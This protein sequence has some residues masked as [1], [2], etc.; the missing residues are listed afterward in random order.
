MEL[1]R[2]V[3][4]LAT[5]FLPDRQRH[6]HFPHLHAVPHHVLWFKLLSELVYKQKRKKAHGDTP[7]IEAAS[8]A[9]EEDYGV[10]RPRVP[11]TCCRNFS[12]SR[13]SSTSS[14]FGIC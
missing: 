3:I 6:L 5:A 9:S 7:Q 12:P 13:Q 4:R 11:S 14:A 1:G 8:L 10:H 2:A